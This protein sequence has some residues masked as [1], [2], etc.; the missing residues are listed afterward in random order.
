MWER[1]WGSL[2]FCSTDSDSPCL[3]EVSRSEISSLTLQSASRRLLPGPKHIFLLMIQHEIEERDGTREVTLALLFGG[4]LLKSQ[5]YT[6]EVKM[7]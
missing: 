2:G 5:T 1:P 4:K 3:M 7:H 6:V